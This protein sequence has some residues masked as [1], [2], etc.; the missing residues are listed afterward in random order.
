MRAEGHVLVQGV[1]GGM[2]WLVAQRHRFAA[3]L[4]VE[5]QSPSPLHAT[6][7]VSR[8]SHADLQDQSRH[9]DASCV[10]ASTD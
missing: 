8:A 9:G 6:R 3:R 4:Q 7:K 2:G 10:C 5:T 1:D